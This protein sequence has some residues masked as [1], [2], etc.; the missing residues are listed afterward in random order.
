MD[1]RSAEPTAAP[2]SGRARVSTASFL[3]AIRAPRATT[4]TRASTPQAAAIAAIAAHHAAAAAPAARATIAS[5]LVAARR[6]PATSH[7]ATSAAAF[8]AENPLVFAACIF[9]RKRG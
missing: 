6:P 2:S 5:T 4:L 3:R 1:A 9:H 7:A 8:P